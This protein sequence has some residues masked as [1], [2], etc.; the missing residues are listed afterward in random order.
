MSD[1][2]I[3]GS[4]SATAPPFVCEFLDNFCTVFV[5]CVSR[6]NRKIRVPRLLVTV[7]VFCLLKTASKCTPDFY[8]G[9]KCFF[10]WGGAQP[11]L[12]QPIPSIPTVPR[13]L[14]TEI[15]NT[16][17]K[18]ICDKRRFKPKRNTK[19][20]GWGKCQRGISFD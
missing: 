14:L 16:P 20:D 2:T 13:S 7:R 3:Q 9:Q 5:S 19:N 10:F 11:L 1:S 6:L 4:D 8:C 18:K 15:L 12:S 17:L